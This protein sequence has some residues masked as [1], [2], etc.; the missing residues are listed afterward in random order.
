MFVFFLTDQQIRWNILLEQWEFL[1]I[2]W[3]NFRNE[4]Q[5]KQCVGALFAIVLPGVICPRQFESDV[6]G[7]CEAVNEASV[8]HPLSLLSVSLTNA[9][10]CASVNT[11]D[12]RMD[13]MS[14]LISLQTSLL[15]AD[16]IPDLFWEF[17]IK[18]GLVFIYYLFFLFLFFW[19]AYVS[20][21]I[22]NLRNG[23]KIREIDWF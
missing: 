19:V 23:K 3:L 6:S 5:D 18:D 17:K 14:T 9:S 13:D 16:Y 4:P 2:S 20:V 11:L 15:T 8:N 7:F 1:L 12:L 22:T 21:V 10:S